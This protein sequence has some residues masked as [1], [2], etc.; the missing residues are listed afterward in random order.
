MRS[1]HLLPSLPGSLWLGMVSP[2]KVL[3]MGQIELFD[4]YTECKQKIYAKLNCLKSN[5]LSSECKQMTYD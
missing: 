2:E 3:S 4:I 5:F 1:I